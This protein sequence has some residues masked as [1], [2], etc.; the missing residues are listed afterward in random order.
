MAEQMTALKAIMSHDYSDLRG[1][2]MSGIICSANSCHPCH[3][4]WFL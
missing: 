3:T 1:K 2:K 4:E